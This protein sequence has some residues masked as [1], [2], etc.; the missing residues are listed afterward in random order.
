MTTTARPVSKTESLYEY[1]EEEASIVG[2]VM[3]ASFNYTTLD[4]ESS[5]ETTFTTVILLFQHPEYKVSPCV[6]FV[7]YFY[8]SREA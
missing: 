1:V 3:Y 2:P 5:N 7:Q 4:G 6:I 8:I